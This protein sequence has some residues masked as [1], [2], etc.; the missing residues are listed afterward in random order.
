EGAHV[1][2]YETKEGEEAL[3]NDK[4]DALI[5]FKEGK[6]LIWLEGSNPSK[7]QS[8]LLV[9]QGMNQLNFSATYWDKS[10]INYLHGSA[11]M[12]AFDNFGPVLIGVFSFFFVFLIAGISFL[13]ESTRG[14]LE[15]L[16]ASPL[17]R[18]EI[19]SGYI[20]GFGIFTLAQA[21]LIAW[22]SIKVLGML[23]VGSFWFVLLVTFMLSLVA[24][25][26]GIL[27]STF[28]NNEFQVIQFI[29]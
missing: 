4:I 21:G 1:T 27:I 23:M 18:Y 24:L 13:R 28:A 3:K 17:R 7:S 14:T 6:P 19:V 8:V 12:T 29:P 11:D 2:R 20:F 16:L 22:F 9:V 5:S 25:T 10:N 15:R 26:I